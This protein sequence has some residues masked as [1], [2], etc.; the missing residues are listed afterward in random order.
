M[1]HIDPILIG[2]D[3]GTSCVKAVMA[4]PG[5]D[6]LDE[7][8][9]PHETARPEPGA[10]EQDPAHWM[11]HVLEALA[12]FADHPRAAQVV[13]LGVTSQVNTHVFCDSKLRPIRPAITWQ[14]TRSAPQAM[15]LDQQISPDAKTAA[16]GAPIPIDASHALSRMAWVAASEPEVWNDTAHVMLPKDFVL[17]QLTGEV[18]ADPISSIGLVGENH[19]YAAAI[20]DLVPRAKDLLP[21]LSDPLSISGQIAQ[22]L[23]FAGKPVCCGTMDAWASMFGLGVT[24]DGEAMYL[25]GTSD[26]LGL[27]SNRGAGYPGIIT[28]PSWR[29]IRLHAGPTQSGGASLN[30]LAAM[31]GRTVT[32]AAG[33]A[34]GLALTNQSPL[35]LP[36]LEGER[37]PLWD[38]DS[39]A[40]FAGLTTAHGPADMAVAVMEGVAFSARLAIEA[41]EKSADQ[42]V[43]A[44]LHGGGGST[45]DAWCQIRANALG[46]RLERVASRHAG[47][48]GAQVMAGTACG[49]L[50][51]LR[52]ATAALVKTDKVFEPEPNCGALADDRF[53]RFRALY[54]QLKPINSGGA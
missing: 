10:A 41:I 24:S 44:L 4:A 8:I 35:F 20:L 53:A 16:L 11:R 40:C 6:V 18:C 39:R 15:V 29:G 13:A 43:Q 45:S 49:E 5:G 33:L 12:R 32:D 42:Q 47:A 26:V 21:P 34:A 28:F 1:S 2:I 17:A 9:K 46:R 7:Y 27:I 22:G 30:W 14:D 52:D 48:V 36:H 31:I 19:T 51:S 3:V 50:G 54:E 37:A 23:P 38:P 25:S